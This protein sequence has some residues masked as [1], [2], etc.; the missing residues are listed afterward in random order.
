MLRPQP[1]GSKA[2]DCSV[3]LEA[4]PRPSVTVVDPDARPL[5]GTAGDQAARKP[6]RRR[7]S[8]LPGSIGNPPI[9]VSVRIGNSRAGS[10]KASVALEAGLEQLRGQRVLVQPRQARMRARMR[11]DRPSGRD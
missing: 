4:E 2:A 3:C 11:T 5:K 10:A 9:N 8:G 7:I 1:G 6:G